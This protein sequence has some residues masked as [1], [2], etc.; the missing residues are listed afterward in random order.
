VDSERG[1]NAIALTIFLVVGA[2]IVFGAWRL[3]GSDVVIR[4]CSFDPETWTDA[5]QTQ[6]DARQTQNAADRYDEM[7]P[8]AADIVKCDDIVYGKRSSEVRDL[9]VSADHLHRR[10]A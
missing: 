1:K 3:T 8:M 4:D 2:L 9:L 10:R 6:N 5:R 7:E